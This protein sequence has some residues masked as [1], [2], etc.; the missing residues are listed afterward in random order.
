MGGSA[1]AQALD[2]DQPLSAID[3]V[4][5][6]AKTK[7]AALIPQEPKVT[8]GAQVPDVSVATLDGPAPKTIGLVP[9]SV[10]GLPKGIWETTDA[11]ILAN[12]LSNMPTLHL[13]AA[14]S[15]MFTLLLAE[16]HPARGKSVNFDIARIDALLGVGALDPALSLMRQIEPSNEP[17][18]A[19][20]YIDASL[21]NETENTACEMIEAAPHL[22]PDYSYR[23]FCAARAGNWDTAA[24]LLGTGRA[25]GVVTMDQAAVLERFLDPDLF[26]DEPPLP[27][28]QTPNALVFRMYEALG[29]PISTRPW[30]VI[31]ANADLRDVQ[32]WKTQID[33]AE[34]LAETGALPANLLLGKYS[35]RKPA[36]SGGVWDRVAAVQRFETALK[37]GS[38][39][40]IAK[41]M[42][43]AWQQMQSARLSGPMATLFADAVLAL[44]LPASLHDIAYSMVQSTA[45]YEVAS[46]KFPIAAAR[47]AFR[48][49]VAAG[50]A[51]A[52]LA[53]TTL[54]MAI[55]KGFQS[56]NADQKIITT[57]ESGAL[58]LAILQSLFA[59][60]AGNQGD[61]GRLSTA[62][63]TLRAIG[64]ED[65]ARRAALQML[66]EQDSQ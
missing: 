43:N 15:L 40:A 47:Y 51:N 61:L 38:S 42:P 66:I 56:P 25:L 37:T 35:E 22:A 58:G 59:L 45:Q 62:L 49:S 7:P 39:D 18:I 4:D 6:L 9:F 13:P 23:I 64:L 1:A 44:E 36:A 53:K 8:T 34:R 14:Q 48:A 16:T 17:A 26:E 11:N 24:L 19:Q 46:R 54:E 30:P 20:R 50:E 63:A 31:Y 27:R 52:S 55:S 12:T 41:T 65:V 57:A 3:W 33:A 2:S 32:G 29:Q 5:Q 60:E 21:L 28:P 10:T